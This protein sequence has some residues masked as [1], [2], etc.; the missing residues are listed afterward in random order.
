MAR[1]KTER[2]ARAQ[3]SGKGEAVDT[4]VD[5]EDQRSRHRGTSATL[6]LAP[7]STAQRGFRLHGLAHE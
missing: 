7:Q 4:E 5:T 3:R 2:Q 6:T 1:P